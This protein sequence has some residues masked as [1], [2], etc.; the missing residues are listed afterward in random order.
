MLPP[1]SRSSFIKLQEN[2]V[3][4]HFVRMAQMLN[5]GKKFE[6]FSSPAVSEGRKINVQFFR[7]NSRTSE[8]AQPR[9][10]D[11]NL[12][13]RLKYY[14]IVFHC[15]R[16]GKNFKSRSTWMRDQR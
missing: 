1:N 8:K 4:S 10:P 3:Q 2:Y 12:N 16:S 15:I 5:I 13:E 9:M 11:K 14:E 7:R 6:D